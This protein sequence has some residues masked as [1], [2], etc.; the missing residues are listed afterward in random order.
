MI[1]AAHP[2]S[3]LQMLNTAMGDAFVEE[4]DA[5]KV[6][7]MAHEGAIVLHRNVRRRGGRRGLCF[8]DIA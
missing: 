3:H 2:L 1:T 5:A 6:D 7:T 8:P 4:I